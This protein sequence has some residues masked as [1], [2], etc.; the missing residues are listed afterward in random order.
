MPVTTLVEIAYESM[1]KAGARYEMASDELCARHKW[2]PGSR[3]YRIEHEGAVLGTRV[4]SW[5]DDDDYYAIVW[6]DETEQPREV[7]YATTRW[8][9]YGNG[10]TVDAT[11]ERMAKWEAWQRDQREAERL[12]RLEE[13][14][15]QPAIGKRVKVVKGRKVPI[16]TEAEVFWYGLDRYAANR[17]RTAY[18][19]GL[20][21]DGE[22]VFIAAQNVE[23]I[24]Q[25]VSA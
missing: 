8:W 16:G 4:H 9:T 18:R 15:A 2:E 22:Q 10:A 25:P 13:E 19:V 7:M 14:A 21:V 6:D 24:R 20:E 1:P 11:P 23:V 5:I 12:Q 17:G 3:A